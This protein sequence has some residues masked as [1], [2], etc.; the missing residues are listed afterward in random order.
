MPGTAT[1]LTIGYQ[2]RTLDELV[3]LLRAERVV[4]LVD[5]RDVPWSHVRGFSKDPR[6]MTSSSA[7]K[8]SRCS[9]NRPAYSSAAA[10]S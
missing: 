6:M 4:A 10:V 5:V 3:G 2:G 9:R 1:V 8:R 7:L